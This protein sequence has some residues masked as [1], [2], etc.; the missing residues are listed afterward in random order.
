MEKTANKKGIVNLNKIKYD[1]IIKKFGPDFS[2]F[3]SYRFFTDS[4][5]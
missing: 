5:W 2:N 4:L 3:N 1:N